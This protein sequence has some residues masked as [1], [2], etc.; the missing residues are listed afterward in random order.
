MLEV[1][2]LTIQQDHDGEVFD[3]H[4]KSY[5]KSDDT[6]QNLG[7]GI[8]LVDPSQPY[9]PELFNKKRSRVNEAQDTQ[10]EYVNWG[11]VRFCL[12][13]H[14]LLNMKEA[15]SSLVFN[16]AAGDNGGWR[17]YLSHKLGSNDLRQAKDDITVLVYLSF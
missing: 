6:L 12:N 1:V 13:T 11:Y 14:E 17:V 10:L 9:A 4:N 15:R 5:Y 2:R 8:V 16:R 7:H 3:Y